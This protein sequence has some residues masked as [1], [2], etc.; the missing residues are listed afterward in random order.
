MGLHCMLVVPVQCR[1][2][3]IGVLG[4]LIVITTRKCSI[5]I[6]CHAISKTVAS[7]T[8]AAY[9]QHSMGTPSKQQ[10]SCIL[11]RCIFFGMV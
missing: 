5:T 3:K 9:V 8:N 2:Y 10:L 1:E 6:L 7:I 11:I 4:Y